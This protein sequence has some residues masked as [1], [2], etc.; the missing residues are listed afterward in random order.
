VSQTAI[1]AATPGWFRCIR[2]HGDTWWLDPVVAWEI[3][4]HPEPRYPD[5]RF[6]GHFARAITGD[7]TEH[8]PAVV[9]MV[10][11]RPD[12]KYVVSSPAGGDVVLED[13]AD[14]NAH[15]LWRE[16]QLPDLENETNR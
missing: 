13:E 3:I 2:Q 8:D 16:C 11:K 1:V 6:A 7:G 12:Q 15:L 5:S 4:P 10:L 9:T 14:L